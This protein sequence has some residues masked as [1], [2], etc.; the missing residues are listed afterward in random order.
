MLQVAS[1]HEKRPKLLEMTQSARQSPKV[2]VS[3]HVELPQ[4]KR[5]CQ[6]RRQGSEIVV[7]QLNHLEHRALHK[8]IWDA[9]ETSTPTDDQFLQKEKR[10]A[11]LVFF[12]ER[13][14][15]YLAIP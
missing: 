10:T 14:A 3:P 15:L 9:P 4:R 13:E 11:A 6:T 7:L 8:T 5:L 12:W 1:L 2:P